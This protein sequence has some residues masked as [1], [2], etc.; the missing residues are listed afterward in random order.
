MLLLVLQLALKLCEELG[1][2]LGSGDLGPEGLDVVGEL[3]LIVGEV[4]A[5]DLISNYTPFHL[6][7]QHSVRFILGILEARL[8]QLSKLLSFLVDAFDAQ[9]VLKF[10]HLRDL[11]GLEHAFEFVLIRGLIR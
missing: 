10:G 9:D 2:V 1:V 6:L 5:L 4:D 7:V 8:L 11:E 3:N